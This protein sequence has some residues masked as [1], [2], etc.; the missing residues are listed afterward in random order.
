MMIKLT[1]AHRKA[2]KTITENPGNV[3]ANI[4]NSSVPADMAKIHA[5]AAGTLNRHGFIVQVPSGRKLTH[6]YRTGF[7]Q[8]FDITVWELTEAGRAAVES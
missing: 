4:Q 2:L 1:E 7:T 5:T 8:T 6:T 3:A